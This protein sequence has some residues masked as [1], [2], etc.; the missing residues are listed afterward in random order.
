MAMLYIILSSIGKEIDIE[1][2]H[3]LNQDLCPSVSGPDVTS[4][5]LPP[6][7]RVIPKRSTIQPPVAKSKPE[8]PAK[9]VKGRKSFAV[10]PSNQLA[11][12]VRLDSYTCPEKPPAAMPPPKV[13]PK[14]HTAS[15]ASVPPP[16]QAQTNKRRSNAVTEEQVETLSFNMEV[17]AE[18][19][20][21]LQRQ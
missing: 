7:G 1:A 17:E 2:I 21:D 4:T 20:T 14:R 11:K 13:A 9:T 16:S 15:V 6:K 3:S 5:Q 18:D 19:D 8:P 10:L 12:P